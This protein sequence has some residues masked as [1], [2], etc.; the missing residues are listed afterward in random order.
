M[1]TKQK[2]NPLIKSLSEY[3]INAEYTIYV[4]R[5]K[6]TF[7]RGNLYKTK[8]DSESSSLRSDGS[9]DSQTGGWTLLD[10]PK[11]AQN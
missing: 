7:K 10:V 9:L 4:N 3:T 6:K 2:E 11:G 1:Q 5:P 8:E